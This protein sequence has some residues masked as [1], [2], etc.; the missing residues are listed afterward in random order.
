MNGSF[1]S[2]HN[3]LLG[4]HEVLNFILYLFLGSINFPAA[5]EFAALSQRGCKTREDSGSE[6]LSHLLRLGGGKFLPLCRLFLFVLPFL[7]LPFLALLPFPYSLHC[8]EGNGGMARAAQLLVVLRMHF[9][10]VA[11]LLC[12]ELRLCTGAA[13]QGNSSACN[14]MH[15]SGGGCIDIELPPK[16]LELARNL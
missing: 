16:S 12:Y 9:G 3:G 2:A 15:A 7:A 1:K 6:I 5:Q 14:F 13:L 4:F 8:M 10:C 11:H